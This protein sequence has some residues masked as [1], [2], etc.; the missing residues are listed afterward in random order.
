LNE[1]GELASYV[2][3]ADLLE[4]LPLLVRG[5]RRA[6]RITLKVVSDETGLAQSTLSRLERGSEV[7]LGNAIILLRWLD[8]GSRLEG[9]PE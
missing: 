7:S 8:Q 6:Q 2:E 3:V 4:Q 1:S 5:A 9:E